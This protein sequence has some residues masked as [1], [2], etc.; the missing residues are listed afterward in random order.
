MLKSRRAFLSGSL[1]LTAGA[2]MPGV[3]IGCALDT[4]QIG[5]ALLTELRQV[6]HLWRVREMGKPYEYINASDIV[7][8][9]MEHLDTLFSED[10]VNGN[11]FEVNGLVLSLRE[12]AMLVA[13]SADAVV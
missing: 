7:G 8:Y 4:A 5:K 11:T 10:F 3:K 12:A 6:C 1:L 9:S 2:V 13:I